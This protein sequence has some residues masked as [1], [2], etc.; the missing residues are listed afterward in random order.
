VKRIVPLLVA[1]LVLLLVACGEEPVFAPAP[2]EGR[3]AA[4]VRPASS[5]RPQLFDATP[6][7]V[8]P[9]PAA[10]LLGPPYPIVLVHGFSGFHELGPLNYF[11]D[12]VSALADEGETEVFSPALPPYNR[13]AERALVLG[14]VVDEV[15]A[16]TGRAQV[17]LIAHSQGG[18][19]SPD[20][21][22][23]PAGKLLAW[24]I[25]A[26]DEPPNE[27]E[28]D[29]DA[30][31]MDDP[32]DPDMVAVSEMMSTAGMEAFNAAHPDPEG[33]R[34][35]SVAG[36]S[37]LRLPPS[38][39][40]EGVWD[41]GSRMDSVDL[42]LVG[43]GLLLSGSGDASLFSPRANDGIVPTD[44]MVR[45]VFL[46]CVPADHFDE[47]GQIADFTPGLISG[48]DHLE[49]FQTL[50]RNVRAFELTLPAP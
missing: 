35:F 7:E 19:D 29:D 30:T 43:S 22:L 41:P 37:N 26:A 10:P 11:F 1:A 44:S 20:G 9:E 6:I 36:Y 21:A 31:T 13:S 34:F 18:L 12:V 27:T 14:Q 5:A 40:D 8:A 2:D 4:T 48:F 47:V 39:C 17:H 15:I 24:L 25:G 46:G 28:W 16:E 49:L 32:W 38:L 3:P 50:V 33:V 42:L 23:N 45:G